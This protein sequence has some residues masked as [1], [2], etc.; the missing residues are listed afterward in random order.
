MD[1]QQGLNQ[2]W[3]QFGIPCFEETSVPDEIYDE[4][5]GK[6]I[7]LEPPYITYQKI[8]GSLDE[9]VYPTASLWTRNESWSE[10]DRIMNAINNALKNGGQIIKIDEGRMWIVRGS[11]FA[12]AMS[13]EDRTIRRYFINLAVEF[14]T[15]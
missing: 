2:F 5:T 11:P 1:K 8:L 3:S 7:P 13:D 4:T 14:F 10:A 12:Q 6:M 9:P 15:E